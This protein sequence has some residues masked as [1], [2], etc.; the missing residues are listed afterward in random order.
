MTY[1]QPF[2][3]Q[4]HADGSG[5]ADCFEACLA[6][7]LRARGELAALD[8]AGALAA[9]SLACRGEPDSPDNPYT[10]LGQA[11]LGLQ[12]YTVPAHLTYD[13]RNALVASWSICLV[14]GTAITKADGSKPYPP[15]W[16]DYET[17]ADHFIL[18]G[19]AFTG[20]FNWIM[21]PLDPARTWAQY[22]LG[23]LQRA[24]SCAYLLPTVPGQAVA[25]PGRWR[26][27]RAFGLLPT[28]RHGA[29]ALALVPALGQGLTWHETRSV[30][31]E[32]W[33][34][35]QFRDR[36]GWAPAAYVT[37]L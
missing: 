28:P 3:S 2:C 33:E 6:A 34:R 4:L 27:Q 37:D 8:D 35:L 10:T 9:V 24:W 23:S 36:L 12:H 20:A 21:N 11:D 1:P 16:F 30:A 31:G 19:P 17:G 5:W 25:T 7:Y 29:T 18:W 32:T 22:D 13:Y 26:A 14:D 15:A